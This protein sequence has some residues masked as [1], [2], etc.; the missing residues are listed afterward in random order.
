MYGKRTNWKFENSKKGMVDFTV[1][2]FSTSF[3]DVDAVRDQH[4]RCRTGAAEPIESI[5]S[6]NPA[7]I[8]PDWGFRP[9]ALRPTLSSGLPLSRGRFL[10]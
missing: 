5:R 4:R 2:H 3:F 1:G 7:A 10:H 8:S 6:G 9:V